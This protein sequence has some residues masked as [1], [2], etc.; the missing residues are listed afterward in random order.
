MKLLLF[1]VDGTLVISGKE[2]DDDMSELLKSFNYKDYELGIVG[3][4]KMDKILEQ[5][6]DSI[7]F[8]HYFSECGCVYYTNFSRDTLK[9]EKIYEK[10]LRNHKQYSNINILIKLA[11]EF[12][13]KVDYDITGHF[14]DLRCGIVYISLIGM[15]AT[16]DERQ[17]FIEK[18][19]INNYREKLLNLL[20]NKESE[21]NDVSKIDIVYGGSVGI[22]IYPKEYDKI[23]IL[24]HIDVN[25]YDQI[26][27]FGDKYL[28]S[29]N[30]YNLLN[31]N[32]LKGFNIDTINDTKILLDKMLK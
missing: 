22:S 10:N 3:G 24:Q 31:S 8:N 17:Y 6:K 14:I 27:Y 12:L 7:Y 18:D 9:L 20:I 11:L 29:G 32:M 21:L 28:K 2:I 1:D 19:K 30:D 26:Y 16:E 13:S 23:Q 25:K 15:T 5:F 4:G